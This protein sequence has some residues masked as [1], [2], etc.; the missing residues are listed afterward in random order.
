MSFNPDLNYAQKVIFSGKITKSFHSQIF[1]NILQCAE[2]LSDFI[3]FS[4]KFQNQFKEQT[5][6]K[7]SFNILPLYKV[8]S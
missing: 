2:I 3:I 1:L 5:N 4:E 8:S 6:N 7:V